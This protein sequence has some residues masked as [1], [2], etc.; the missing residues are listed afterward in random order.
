MEG[1]CKLDTGM[2][3]GYGGLVRGTGMRDGHG[4]W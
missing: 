4:G 1:K 2:R 3:D